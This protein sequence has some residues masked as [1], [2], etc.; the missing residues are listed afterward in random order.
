MTFSKFHRLSTTDVGLGAS[1]A[2]AGL[3]AAIALLIG[4]DMLADY[5]SGTAVGHL[6][7]E[8]AVMAL[9]LAGAASLWRQLRIAHRQADQLTV[10]LA[11][12]RGEAERFRDEAREALRGLGEAIDS[13]FTRWGLTAAERE[14]G[15]LLLKG[16]SHKEVAAMR[17]TGETTIRQQA[18]AIYRK[19]GLRNRSDLSAFF[20]EDLLLPAGER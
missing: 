3:F 10:D 18:L 15:L 20:L 16:L 19:S 12:A 17:S 8:G 13:Q 1:A 14:V 6:L 5:R 4:I 9:A 2:A 11:A 7:T